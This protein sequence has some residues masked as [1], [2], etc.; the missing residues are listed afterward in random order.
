MIKGLVDDGEL[1]TEAAV[2]EIKEETGLEVIYFN[3]T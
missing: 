3:V 1:I 2:R